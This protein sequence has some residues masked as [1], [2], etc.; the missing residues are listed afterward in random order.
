MQRKM[1]FC[2][3]MF[4]CLFCQQGLAQDSPTGKPDTRHIDMG[5]LQVPKPHR[6]I[7]VPEAEYN[8][9]SGSL[10]ITLDASCYSEYTITLSSGYANVDYYPSSSVVVFPASAL[11][12]ITY[13]Y[14]DSED[15]GTYE[16]VLD[17][18]AIGNT[19]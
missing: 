6:I 1:L 5:T 18:N 16:G 11:S 8:T 2:L 3:L 9:I 13:I 15:C 17:M 4:L 12:E 10:T 7:D 14:I 19:Y